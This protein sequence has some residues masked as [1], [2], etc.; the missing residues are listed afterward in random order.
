MIETNR[1]CR[2]DL[3]Y[4][5][6]KILRNLEKGMVKERKSEEGVWSGGEERGGGRKK[7]MDKISI[8]KGTRPQNQNKKMIIR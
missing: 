2:S 3:F 5:L 7:T 4:F 8:L 1:V 6:S